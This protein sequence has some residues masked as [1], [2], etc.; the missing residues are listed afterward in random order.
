MI[1]FFPYQIISR[2]FSFDSS[3]FEEKKNETHS[4]FHLSKIKSIECVTHTHEYS[5]CQWC[6]NEWGYDKKN[7]LPFAYK[8]RKKINPMPIYSYHIFTFMKFHKSFK[9]T[10][11]LA[12]FQTKCKILV[13]SSGFY[14]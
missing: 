2:H 1:S 3:C 11:L 10:T 6:T 5:V 4:Q 9:A 14:D 12:T 7:S 8:K 13:R